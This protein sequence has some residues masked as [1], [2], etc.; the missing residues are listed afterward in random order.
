[1]NAPGPLELA[2]SLPGEAV[3][4]HV[5]SACEARMFFLIPG[6]TV[7]YLSERVAHQTESVQAE[8]LLRL[9]KLGSELDALCA[10]MLRHQQNSRAVMQASEAI[11]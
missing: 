7:A 11:S 2:L 4:P 1:M 3:L 9:G 10:A 8:A 6:S 5:S